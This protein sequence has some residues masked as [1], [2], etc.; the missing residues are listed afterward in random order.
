MGSVA[1]W[2][3]MAFVILGALLSCLVCAAVVALVVILIVR[4]VKKKKAAAKIIE[5]EAEETPSETTAE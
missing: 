2:L 4:K 1:G 5:V 3:V